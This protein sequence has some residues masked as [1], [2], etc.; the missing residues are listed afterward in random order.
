MRT[1]SRLTETE[2]Q[3]LLVLARQSIMASA[4]GLHPPAVE[5]GL[6]AALLELGACF[7]TI[8]RSTTGELRGCTGVLVAQAPLAE[9]VIRTAAQTACAD[10]RFEPVRPDEVD[11]LT[12]EISVLTPPQ[13]LEFNTPAE[14]PHLIRPGIDG[15]TLIF[16]RA[17]R[18]TFLP[19]VWE[20][21]ADPIEF[22]DRLCMKMGLPAGAWRWPGMCAE[23]YQVQEFHEAEQA[24]G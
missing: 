17:Y 11:D 1:L 13:P 15:V 24:E 5:P 20:K 2:Q 10:P 12:I 4:C 3:A 21:I 6:P 16:H 22:L 7:V 23:V 9:E 18:A 19:Q 14:L 8:N